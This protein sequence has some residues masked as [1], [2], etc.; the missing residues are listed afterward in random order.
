MRG[1]LDDLELFHRKSF[2]NS[3]IPVTSISNLPEAAGWYCSGTLS[4]DSGR[5]I[6]T[7]EN[8]NPI[9]RFSQNE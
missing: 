3:G 1:L 5:K 4:P 9:A 6:T 2:S 7:I 8:H